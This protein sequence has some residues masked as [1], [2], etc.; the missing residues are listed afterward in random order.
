MIL[1]LKK[2][3]LTINFIFMVQSF[4]V[5][6][7]LLFQISQ[8]NSGTLPYYLRFT[9]N[10][11]TFKTSLKT[12]LF[13]RTFNLHYGSQMFYSFHFSVFVFHLFQL[14]FSHAFLNRVLYSCKSFEL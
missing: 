14:I 5:K 4:P 6:T 11:N 1:F 8:L 9:E 13:K 2:E 10:I 7:I 3:F 12:F